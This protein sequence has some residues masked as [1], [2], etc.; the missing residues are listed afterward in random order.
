MGT[1]YYLHVKPCNHCGHAKRT[2][3][4]GKSSIGWTFSFHGYP[5]SWDDPKILC[6]QDWVDYLQTMTKT[7]GVIKDEYDKAV[8]LENLL[9]LIESKKYERLN[10]T[11]YCRIHHPESATWDSVGSHNVG[12]IRKV[13]DATSHNGYSYVFTP[14]SEFKNF[15][16]GVLREIDQFLHKLEEKCWICFA[17]KQR[18]MCWTCYENSIPL[19]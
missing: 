17:A 12:A 19:E 11:T 18:G 16:V 3:H 8:P 15:T 14:S 4:I 2:I 10:H 13:S 7:D 1:N 5:N 9:K 6:Y